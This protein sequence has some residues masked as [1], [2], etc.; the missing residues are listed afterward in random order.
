MRT[1]GGVE[2]MSKGAGAVSVV[3][4]VMVGVLVELVSVA[5]GRG[6][7]DWATVRTASDSQTKQHA[8]DITRK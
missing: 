8:T 6:G 2:K 4:S 7:V 3:V 5:D 1:G